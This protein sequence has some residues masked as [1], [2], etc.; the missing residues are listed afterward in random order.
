MAAA[1]AATAAA[2]VSLPLANNNKFTEKWKK[3]Y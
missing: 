1:A 3:V 2:A